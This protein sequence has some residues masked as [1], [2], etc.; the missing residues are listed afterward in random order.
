MLTL[1]LMLAAAAP[2]DAALGK[3]KFN[4]AL[5]TYE[6]GPAPRESQRIWERVGDK[7]HFLHTGISQDGK[8]FRTEFTA[9]Y[10]GRDYPVD[11]GSLYNTVALKLVDARTVEQTFKKDGKVTVRARRTVSVDG[12]RLTIIAEGENAQGKK[13]K[14]T[15]VYER[16]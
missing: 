1:V 8:S 7:A 6:S 11:G 2:E 14:N 10:D 16:Q 5:S 12:K 4:S 3:W 13:F 9:S 15:L